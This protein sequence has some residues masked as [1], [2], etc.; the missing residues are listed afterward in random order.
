MAMATLTLCYN[1]PNVFTGVVK[2]RRGQAVELMMTATNMDDF[3]GV[4]FRSAK[5]LL[6]KINPLD[7]NA[8]ET[9]KIACKILSQCSDSLRCSQPVSS[10]CSSMDVYGYFGAI[11]L[12]V[13]AVYTALYR[14]GLL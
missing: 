3:K 13:L 1:N 11:T 14:Y 5:E 9:Q 7:P 8:V 6:A 12:I 10:W 2:I 4:M